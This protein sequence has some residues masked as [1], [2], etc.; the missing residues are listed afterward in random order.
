MQNT[1]LDGRTVNHECRAWRTSLCTVWTDYK[2]PHDSMSHSCI[3]IGEWLQ[4]YGIIDYSE[5]LHTKLHLLWSS[6]GYGRPTFSATSSIFHKSPSNSQ[7]M[8][9]RD[10]HLQRHWSLTGSTH[11]I[12]RSLH[13]QSIQSNNFDT[14]TLCRRTHIKWKMFRSQEARSLFCTGNSSYLHMASPSVLWASLGPGV[15]LNK[16]FGLYTNLALLTR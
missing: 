8:I 16:L 13:S 9:K 14:P 7:R 1:L 15:L 11:S 10:H 12:H 6:W 5:S 2:K 4:L 3:W